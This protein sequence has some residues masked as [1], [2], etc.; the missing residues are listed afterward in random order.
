MDFG[1]LNVGCFDV[2]GFQNHAFNGSET[3]N[4]KSRVSRPCAVGYLAVST[5]VEPY[6]SSCSESRAHIEVVPDFWGEARLHPAETETQEA[7]CH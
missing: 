2:A 4:L 1:T 6:V 7:S 5:I 3:R